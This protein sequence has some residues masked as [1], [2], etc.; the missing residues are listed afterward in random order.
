MRSWQWH[1]PNFRCGEARLFEYET[2]CAAG[3][4]SEKANHAG[5]NWYAMT[6]LRTEVHRE[7]HGE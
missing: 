6:V 4:D 2:A 1:S 7:V 5:T 3:A